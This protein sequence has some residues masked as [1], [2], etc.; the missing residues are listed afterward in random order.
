MS[1]YKVKSILEIIYKLC[2]GKREKEVSAKSF[3]PKLNMLD[4]E[5]R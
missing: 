3:G 4:Q 2:P 5:I 1:F